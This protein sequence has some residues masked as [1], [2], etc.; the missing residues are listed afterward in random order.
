M[1]VCKGNDPPNGLILQKEKSYLGQNK[2]NA[3]IGRVIRGAK[4]FRGS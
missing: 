1:I 2:T 4:V 3:C